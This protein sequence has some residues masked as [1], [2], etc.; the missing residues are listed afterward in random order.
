MREAREHVLP[1]GEIWMKPGPDLQEIADPTVDL[2]GASRWLDQS[3]NHLEHRRLAGAVPADYG[4]LL[5]A[6]NLYVDVNQGF[7][8]TEVVRAWGTE[9]KQIHKPVQR[10][11]VKAID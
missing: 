9:A 1:P 2:H 4:Q 10:L 11:L 8:F 3:R 6:T 5:A 7:V